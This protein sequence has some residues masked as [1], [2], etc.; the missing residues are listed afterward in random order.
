MILH[1]K[2]Q[3]GKISKFQSGIKPKI[4]VLRRSWSLSPHT[5]R[6]GHS[7]SCA[8]RMDLTW[9]CVT[10]LVKFLWKEW[11]Y[12]QFKCKN[13]THFC[14]VLRKSQNLRKRCIRKITYVYSSEKSVLIIFC[15]SIHL[16]DS[17][18]RRRQKNMY[19]SQNYCVFGLYQS[20]DIPETRNHNVSETWSVSFLRCGRDT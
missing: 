7:C 4:P 13:F 20:F 9:R 1:N 15:S 5:T 2:I 19:V 11:K 16:A 6:T 10:L 17:R 18:L 8:L 14:L 3:D 12:M